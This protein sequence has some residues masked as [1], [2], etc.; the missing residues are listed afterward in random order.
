M[1]ERTDR[2]FRYFLRLL[3]SRTLLYT[4]MVSTGAIV[5]GDVRR[6]L[7]FDPSEHPLALQIGGSD[8]RAMARC[9][10]EADAFGYDEVNINVGCPSDRVQSGKFGACL[11]TEPELVARCVTAMRR[12]TRLPVTV[13]TRI[14]VDESDAYE[15]L[16]HFVEIVAA[17]G[18]ETF[19]IHARK[20]WL[21]G[22][23]PK[24]NRD[25]PPLRY[26]VVRR[27]KRDFPYLTVILN[28]G[29]RTLADARSQLGPADNV[30]LDGVMI[31]R[32]AY[33]DPYL[34]A[35]ADSVF[36]DDSH[37]V[38]TRHEALERYLPY[39]EARLAEGMRLHQVTRH[40]LGLFQGI[41]GARAWRRYLGSE[42][43]RPGANGEVILA[44][45][46]RVNPMVRT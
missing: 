40:L 35:A 7:A 8:P 17:A 12:V 28:G 42:V 18:C 36:F 43:A 11:M 41:S 4:E 10:V 38:P 2:H 30:T 6:F 3:T 9:A 31:G 25:V 44:A 21:S 45:A 22:L 39:V 27:I 46:A 26:D 23:S 34:L 1:M 29:V 20:A 33:D 24:Q 5:H 19:I 15:D 16:A 37:P 14:G 13:K 32:A